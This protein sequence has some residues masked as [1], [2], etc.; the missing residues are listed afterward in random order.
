MSLEWIEPKTDWQAHY[1]ESGQFTGD[2]VNVEDY[3]RIKNNFLYLRE[4]IKKIFFN[5]PVITVG[6]DKHTPENNN[7]DFDNDNF[8]A[9]EWNLIEDALETLDNHIAVLNHGDKQTFY[10]NGAF[11]SYS[12]LNRLEQASLDI[13][14]HITDSERQ[15]LHLSFRLGMRSRA[16]RP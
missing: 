16:I 15:K 11:I 14:T 5:P 10:E 13:Y 6:V 2:Y 8:F 7:P 9:D 1:D 3:N 12:E 4:Y